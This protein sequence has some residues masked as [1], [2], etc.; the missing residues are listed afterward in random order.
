MC[1]LVGTAPA[2]LSKRAISTSR[3]RRPVS[4]RSANKAGFLHRAASSKQTSAYHQLAP[5]TVQNFSAS[6]ATPAQ[7][8]VSTPHRP[9]P[10]STAPALPLLSSY[11]ISIRTRSGAGS[12][13]TRFPSGRRPT[14]KCVSD[15]R[16]RVVRRGVSGSAELVKGFDMWLEACDW[17]GKEWG[18]FGLRL[19][20]KWID[21]AAAARRVR[22]HLLVFQ[23]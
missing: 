8:S 4:G 14:K 7:N 11:R 12:V 22:L 9:P 20:Y 19:T 3:A 10:P 6:L 1:N 16:Y 18:K 17:V 5:F 2:P 23:G 13:I 21:G 15:A